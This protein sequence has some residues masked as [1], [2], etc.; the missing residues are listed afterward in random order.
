MSISKQ[1][2]KILPRCIVTIISTF[3]FGLMAQGSGLFN[4][5][6][7][8]DD[9]NFLAKGDNAW[10]LGRWMLQILCMITS[11]LF[12]DDLFSLPL[13]NG[14]ISLGLIAIAGCL[15]VSLLD[16]RSR[17]LCGL[18][19]AL[20]A[21]F[22][23]V[24]GMFGYIYVAPYYM[25]AF[26]LAA[27][28]VLLLFR[29]RKWWSCLAAVVLLTCAV[30][31]YQAFLPVI[32]SLMLFALISEIRDGKTEKRGILF[33]IITLAATCLLFMGLYYLLMKFF[34]FYTGNE[35][36]NYVGLSEMESSTIG[37]YLARIGLAYR[38]FFL[39]TAD[40]VY[41]MFPGSLVRFYGLLLLLALILIGMLYEK[42]EWRSVLP[43]I[44]T[45]FVPL[46][47]NFIFV[48]VPENSIHGLMMYGQAM[49]PVF[50]IGLADRV[51]C[52]G[53]RISV[54]FA[55]GCGAVL[56]IMILLFCR[57]DNLCYLKADFTQSGMIRY[58]TSLIT[59]IQSVE[60]YDSAMPVL[61]INR[62]DTARDESLHDF[63]EFEHIRLHPYFDYE[64]A[65]SDYSWQ[66]FME[67]RFGFRPYVLED[68]PLK[69][70]E[71]VRKMPA[72]PQ[73]GSIRLIEGTIVVKF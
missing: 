41:N 22:P 34:L 28:G 7:F 45:A 61:Y 40:A 62:P 53:K 43:I 51:L 35:L 15:I 64:R 55:A 20:L 67:R 30:G 1:V 59:R 65:I 60:G 17:C 52:S 13:F 5:Y 25:F 38:E 12:G 48:M 56:G 29:F 3:L 50:C 47:C 2:K 37:M 14:L 10:E 9:I 26:V 4:K 6:S 57:F 24:T 69:D 66:Q 21:V 19:G 68:S 71:E 11:R 18:L 46:A 44:L 27:A 73:D 33:R 32:L 49:F 58:Y 42:N 36:R 54:Y 39:P 8:H 72:Y 63:P 16:I 23:T 31:I 70:S